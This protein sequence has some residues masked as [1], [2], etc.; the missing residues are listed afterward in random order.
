MR[1]VPFGEVISYLELA[2]RAGNARELGR[3][4]QR[5]VK[6]LARSLFLVIELYVDDYRLGGFFGEWKRKRHSCNERDFGFKVIR[7]LILI[8][9]R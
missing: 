5:A 6:I 8:N 2:K 3:L 1:L 7:S 9:H 4:H